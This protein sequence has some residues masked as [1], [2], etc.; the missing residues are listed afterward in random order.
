MGSPLRVLHIGNIANNA[1]NIVKALRERTDIEADCY[2]NHYRHYISQPEWEDAD[3]DV[4]DCN[5][6]DPVSWNT[7]DLKG[8]QRPSWYFETRAEMVRHAR[9][10]N[11]K[12]YLRFLQ[13]VQSAPISEESVAYWRTL[14]NS[15][16][17]SP[18]DRRAL[19]QIS[20]GK[21]PMEKRHFPTEKMWWAYLQKEFQRLCMPPHSPLTS[22]DAEKIV[23]PSMALFVKEY[24]IIQTYG[25]WELFP[26]LVST[27]SIPRI[28]FEHGTMREFP[29]QHSALGRTTMFAY[30]TAFANIITN[31]DAIHNAKRMGLDNYVFIPHPV[32]DTKFCPKPD[33]V[34]RRALLEEHSATHIFLALARQNWALKGNDCVLH[35]FAAFVR[36]VGR[37][38]KLLLGRWGQE[39][40]RTAALI[41]S[42]TL[43]D[44]VAWLPPL[45]KRL[46]ARYINASDAVLDQFIL[47]A[48][49]TT[50]PEA[51]ACGKPV[52][53]YYNAADHHWCLPQ[54]PPVCN[55]RTAEE[56]TNAL[57]RLH[58]DGAY[59]HSLGEA[60]HSWFNKYHS[61][62][63]VVGRHLDIYQRVQSSIKSVSVPRKEIHDATTLQDDILCVVKCTEMSEGDVDFYLKGVEGK[64]F[65]AILDVRVRAIAPNAHLVLYLTAQHPALEAEAR[66]LQWHIAYT[67]E[68]TWGYVK[69]LKLNLFRWLCSVK[70]VWFC[71]LEYPFLQTESVQD[72]QQNFIDSQKIFSGDANPAIN[73][74]VPTRIV[75]RGF[76]LT[77]ALL[78][79][80]FKNHFSLLQCI[81]ILVRYGIYVHAP[82]LTPNTLSVNVHSF[83]DLVCG[84]DP[85]T[86]TLKQIQKD[87]FADTLFEKKC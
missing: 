73:P 1:Y 3:I 19:L 59:A 53:L 4:I 7:I 39:I 9:T 2:T 8:F 37:G 58:G 17:L 44:H 42:L 15:T 27:P 28:T 85:C 80:F 55:V 78:R 67:F 56:I 13:L 16:H 49:G 75:S 72:W 81:S 74:Y 83:S 36:K 65:L 82:T 32:D 84:L 25:A 48:F 47:G 87:N 12:E 10:M 61:L 52:L 34:F 11:P 69:R 22:D 31:A 60:G 63:V 38:P 76:A 54:A 30:K 41:R 51:L 40:E 43:Q 20:L 79:M 77:F 57:V 71:S 70:Y 29:F 35:A 5:D 66:R 24:D 50:M 21:V 14:I 18:H 64:S 68:R 62:D 6:N 86:F 26:S 46:L 23:M 33:P 45:P